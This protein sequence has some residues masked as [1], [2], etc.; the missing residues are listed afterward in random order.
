MSLSLSDQYNGIVALYKVLGPANL[1]GPQLG[2]F[3]PLLENQ[4]LYPQKHGAG[5]VRG[6][7]CDSHGSYF[8]SAIEESLDSTTIHHAARPD[9]Q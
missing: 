8:F 2:R 6:E 9:F 3:S 7:F 5:A 4:K 1:I